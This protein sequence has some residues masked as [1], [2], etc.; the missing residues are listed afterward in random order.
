MTEGEKP[1]DLNEEVKRIWN[2]NTEWWDDR[3]GDGNQFQVQLIEPVTERLIEIAPGTR[4]LDV[5]CGAGRFARRMAELGAEVVA[6]DLSEKF[7]ARA[8]SRT[9]AEMKN[10][11]YR[12]VDATKREELLAL[13]AAQFDGAVSSMALMDME[14]IDPLMGALATLLRPGG[15]FVFS[16]CHPCFQAPDAVRFAESTDAGGKV[17]NRT[18]MKVSQYLT[19]GTTKGLGIIG[20]P[21]PQYYFHRPLSVLFGAG[22]RNGF[23]ID[24]L[25][26]PRLTPDPDEDRRLKWLRWDEM[27]EI[28]PVLVVRMRLM[29]GR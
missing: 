24:A 4:V 9:P 14:D 1:P 10:V 8:K 6:I 11:E 16:I 22:F 15:W 28:P 5:A 12:V 29:K 21:E 23:V 13:G 2:A 7:I 3:I 25:E 18:G 17:T 26:E 19:P 27:T 20:Q